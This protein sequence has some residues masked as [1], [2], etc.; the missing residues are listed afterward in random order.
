[1]HGETLKDVGVFS[2]LFVLLVE[3]RLCP[4]RRLYFRFTA[5]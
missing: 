5:T 1:M 4:G 3:M 2:S